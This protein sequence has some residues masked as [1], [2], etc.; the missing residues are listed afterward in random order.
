MSEEQ[1][2]PN[3]APRDS[4]RSRPFSPGRTKQVI[5]VR[6]GN[7]RPRRPNRLD[8]PSSRGSAALFVRLRHDASSRPR[9]T[10][11]SQ[12]LRGRTWRPRSAAHMD[13]GEESPVPRPARRCLAE[14]GVGHERRAS[15]PAEP[16]SRFELA[17]EE[18]GLSG[19]PRRRPRGNSPSSN[20]KP[21]ARIRRRARWSRLTNCCP[22]RG[23]VRRPRG[24]IPA[25]TARSAAN[26][27]FIKTCRPDQALCSSKPG[28]F[29]QYRARY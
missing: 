9:S 14:L 21:S 2:G 24:A 3:L 6:L 25:I 27:S 11:S 17:G 20:W 8:T 19:P 23:P 15:P 10:R 4:R 1:T 18:V 29:R 26:P 16:N 28:R 13:M 5:A 22:T 12:P 7:H